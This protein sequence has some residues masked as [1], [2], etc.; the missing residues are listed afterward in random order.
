MK[1]ITLTMAALA[2]AGSMMAQDSGFS[3]GLDL[4]MPMGDMGDSYS[5]GV[6]P[7]LSYEREA[8]SSGL[9]GFSL[10]YTIMFPKS[11]LIQSGTVIPIQAHYKYFFD[12]V[13]EGIYIGAMFGLGIQMMKTKEVTVGGITVGGESDS[14]VG[15]G[16][17]PVVGYVLNERLDLGLRYQ[18]LM[19]SKSNDGTVT[20]GS[21][22]KASAYLGVRAAYN[23]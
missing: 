12:D 16:L 19:T 21:G 10:A 2:I 22:S 15:L 14:N 5:F 20:A 6:G 3:A 18:I 7:V 11:D 17:A 13:R 4:A 8:G 1:K 9:G 23:F